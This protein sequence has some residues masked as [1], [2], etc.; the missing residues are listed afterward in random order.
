MKEQIPINDLVTILETLADFGT[1]T[2]DSEVLTEHVRQSLKRTIV[3]QY[4]GEDSTL[5]VIT[6]HPEVEELV[7]KSIQKTTTGS[8]PILKPEVIT[9][10]L[11]V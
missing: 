10:I 6:L 1:A 7:T 3:K 4:L 8:I 9:Q 11:I 5:R 2:K